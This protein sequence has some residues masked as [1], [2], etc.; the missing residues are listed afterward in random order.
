MDI[1]VFL[2]FVDMYVKCGFIYLGIRVL[3]VFLRRN[4]V[5]Y[6][7]VILGFGLYGYVFEVFRL[8]DEV[9]ERG[10]RF[11]EFIFFVFFNACS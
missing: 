3:N 5:V 11:D 9:L 2:V 6:N 1:T 10:F 4:I 7:F 8:F